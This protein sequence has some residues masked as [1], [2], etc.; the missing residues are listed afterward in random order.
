MTSMEGDFASYDELL[1]RAYKL[2]PRRRSKST[3]ERFVLPR[4]EVNIT[5]KRVYI[6]NFKE[7]AETLN[8]DPHV[9]LRFLL[10]EVALPGVYD[11][12]VAVI[13]GEV[14]PQLLN[15]LLERFFNEYVKCPICESPDTLLVKEKKIMQIKC[16]ACGAI[17]PVKPF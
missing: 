6:I 11:E 7:V 14:S 8:R 9:L 10:K 3:G 1:E 5:G 4:F 2:L 16:M 12:G 13:Q 15:K 17:S